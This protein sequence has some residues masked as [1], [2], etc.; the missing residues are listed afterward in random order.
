MEA[1]LTKDFMEIDEIVKLRTRYL[2]LINFLVIICVRSVN[3]N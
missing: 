3:I 2:F 1:G